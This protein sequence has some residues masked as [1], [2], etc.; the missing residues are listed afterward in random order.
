MKDRAINFWWKVIPY[1]P[2]IVLFAA[3]L[4]AVYHVR[5]YR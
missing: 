4:V 3:V 1:M 2:F 5:F